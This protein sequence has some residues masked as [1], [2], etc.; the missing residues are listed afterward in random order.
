MR[1]TFGVLKTHNSEYTINTQK[2]AKM[3]QENGYR[4]N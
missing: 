4:K 2:G 3:L 1:V